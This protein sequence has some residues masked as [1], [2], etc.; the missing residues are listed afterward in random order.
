MAANGSK[1]PSDWRLEINLHI[2]LNGPF[3]RSFDIIGYYRVAERM[4][5]S[6]PPKINTAMR[7][8]TFFSDMRQDVQQMMDARRA[9]MVHVVAFHGLLRSQMHDDV[10][11]DTIGEHRQW[12]NRN[13]KHG[14]ML[15]NLLDEHEVVIGRV[16]RF[17]DLAEA[18]W[19][20]L[21]F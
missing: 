20:R 3:R 16:Y 1:P 11:L 7:H 17:M 13:C 14:Y 8:P 10:F 9:C 2:A 18:T 12:L 5:T 21:K 4:L 15:D 19:F 6:G